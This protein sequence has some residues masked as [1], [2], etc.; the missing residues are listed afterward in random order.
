MCSK[1]IGDKKR[2]I[3]TDLQDEIPLVVLMKEK[4]KEKDKETFC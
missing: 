1:R 3:Y 2:L 4:G